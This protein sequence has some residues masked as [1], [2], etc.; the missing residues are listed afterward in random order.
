VGLGLCRIFIW[1]I[2]VLSV[3]GGLGFPRGGGGGEG[4]G[5]SGVTALGSKVNI[6]NEKYCVQQIVDSL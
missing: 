1:G 4:G 6:L 3:G 5:A 2:M